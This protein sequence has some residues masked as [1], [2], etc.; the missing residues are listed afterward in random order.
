VI[1]KISQVTL[2]EMAGT[3]RSRVSF[4]MNR[5]S[6]HS[7]IQHNG[8]LEIQSSLLNVVPHD[9]VVSQFRLCFSSRP[10]RI[11]RVLCG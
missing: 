1:P 3:M 2:A 7:F 8:E 5:F 11:L 10:L 9:P 6:E 4:F